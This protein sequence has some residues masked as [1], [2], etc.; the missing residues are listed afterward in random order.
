MK[1]FFAAVVAAAS[2][3]AT[4]T[5]AAPPADQ[6]FNWTGF[7]AGANAGYSWGRSDT[8]ASDQLHEALHLD[9]M[10]QRVRNVPAKIAHRGCG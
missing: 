2:F 1:K 9:T 8:D 7:Y 5:L 10:V 4:A 3:C 6:M